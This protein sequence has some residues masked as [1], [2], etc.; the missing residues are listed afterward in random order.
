M[1]TIIKDFRNT[2]A[3]TTFVYFCIIIIFIGV[4]SRLKIGLNIIFAI[5]MAVII[6]LYFNSVKNIDSEQTDK[7][8]E[9]KYKIIKPVPQKIKSY[10]DIIDFLF[11]IQDFYVYNPPVYENLIDTIDDF[12]TLYEEANND[13]ALYGTNFLLA[14]EKK[15]NAVNILHSMI[16]SLPC[17]VNNVYTSKLNKATEKLNN[18]LD[19]YL[20]EMFDKNKKYIYD[21]GVNI[22]TIF[23]TSGPKERNFYSDDKYTHDFY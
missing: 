9:E 10:S 14:E 4:F 12:F 18:I 7:Q 17:S 22:D 11:S 8:Y 16:F 21:N 23:L 19:K 3:K 2:D 6:I 20:D 5:V 13:N 1:E 15:L